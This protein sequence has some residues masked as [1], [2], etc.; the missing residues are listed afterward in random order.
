MSASKIAKVVKATPRRASCPPHTP[1]AQAPLLPLRPLFASVSTSPAKCLPARRRPFQP[2]RTQENGHRVTEQPE[3]QQSS[4]IERVASKPG[5]H[6]G[7]DHREKN[8]H[9]P[10]VDRPP[11]ATDDHEG[12]SVD[13]EQD[14]VVKNGFDWGRLRESRITAS[15]ECCESQVASSESLK[16]GADVASDLRLTLLATCDPD[17]SRI[18]TSDLLVTST[19]RTAQSVPPALSARRS[20]ESDRV[21]TAVNASAAP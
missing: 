15:R 4:R 2:G 9:T 10:G 17:T 1:G 7:R 16:S 18:G 20:S 11:T 14:H 6:D 19:S 13:G 3:R 8:P 12:A 5:R 21:V